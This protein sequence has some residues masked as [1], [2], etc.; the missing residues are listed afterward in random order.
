MPFL[1]FKRARK[2]DARHLFFAEMKP[3]TDHSLTAY[4]YMRLALAKAYAGGIT[5]NHRAY[6]RERKGRL[7]EQEVTAEKEEKPT[8]IADALL[9]AREAVQ[10]PPKVAVRRETTRPPP[11][12]QTPAPATSSSKTESNQPGAK[13]KAI[14]IEPVTL[15][16][17]KRKK[18]GNSEIKLNNRPF[19][20][21][22][23]NVNK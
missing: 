12:N 13:R 4:D 18:I 7:K 1:D 17:K 8:P 3:I 9:P 14:L 20:G 6:E 16:A 21:T 10:P 15:P 19:S 5:D 22:S 11:T 23:K 2:K